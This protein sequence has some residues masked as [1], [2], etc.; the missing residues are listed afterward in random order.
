MLSGLKVT[1][2]LVI[3]NP[4]VT[5]I[6]ELKVVVSSGEGPVTK[7]PI[8]SPTKL[9]PTPRVLPVILLSIDVIV[10]VIF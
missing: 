2:G 7:D 8:V 6:L 10:P 1:S 4:S 3:L 5:K 9:Y